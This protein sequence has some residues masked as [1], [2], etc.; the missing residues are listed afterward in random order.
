MLYRPEF[1]G[2]ED[3]CLYSPISRVY[4][5]SFDLTHYS[6]DFMLSYYHEHC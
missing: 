6:V 4:W 2:V 1:V 5:L 3:W